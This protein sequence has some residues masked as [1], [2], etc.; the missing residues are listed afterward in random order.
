MDAARRHRWE[1]V[2]N[3]DPTAQA[4]LLD[5]QDIDSRLDQAAHRRRTLPEHAEISRLTEARTAIDDEVVRAETECSDLELDQSKADADVEQVRARAARDQQRLDSG[6]VGSAKDLENLQHE[7]TSLARRQA[8]LEDVELEIMERLEIAQARLRAAAAERDL[9]D[10]DLKT[11][12]GRRDA[13]LAA[14]DATTDGLDGERA[15]LA[16]MLPVDLLVLY[17]KL[18]AQFGGVGAAVL[19]QGRCEGCR[20]EIN[21]TELGRIRA[22]PPEEVVRCQECRRILVRLADSRL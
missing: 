3:A 22:A 10:A 7:L 4:R 2:L 20:L 19:R 14:I 12:A 18:R 15:T 5:L 8:A 1:P 11:Q 21:A 9:L 16:A 13:E 17:E 6:Q